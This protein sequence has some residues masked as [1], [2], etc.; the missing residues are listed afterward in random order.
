MSPR[1]RDKI[2]VLN[3]LVDFHLPLEGRVPLL[4]ILQDFDLVNLVIKVRVTARNYRLLM[5][6]RGPWTLELRAAFLVPQLSF[7]CLY[8]LWL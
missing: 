2:L 6:F 8:F 4:I 7:R 5:Q 3:L 1:I